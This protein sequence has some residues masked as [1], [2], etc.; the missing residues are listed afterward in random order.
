MS[1]WPKVNFE[2]STQWGQSSGRV[3]SLHC[4]WMEAKQVPRMSRGYVP[5]HKHCE[6][7]GC[8]NPFLPTVFTIFTQQVSLD[9]ACNG[10][11]QFLGSYV[12]NRMRNIHLSSD[13]VRFSPPNKARET[14]ILHVWVPKMQLGCMIAN[15]RSNLISNCRSLLG[16]TVSKSIRRRE[17]CYRE[18]A[19]HGKFAVI[20]D[21]SGALMT[22]KSAHGIACTSAR[23]KLI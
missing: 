19:T 5:A 3:E 21:Q 13:Q 9:Q 12:V 7:F 6:Q 14:R 17:Q 15:A 18:S 2:S 11:G 20:I 23:R 22:A 10:P 8:F 4:T 16:L 1:N